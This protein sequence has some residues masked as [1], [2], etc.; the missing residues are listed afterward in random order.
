MKKWEREEE[1]HMPKTLDNVGLLCTSLRQE[2]TKCL[3]VQ[4]KIKT[5]QGTSGVSDSSTPTDLRGTDGSV[6]PFP[7]IHASL[8]LRDTVSTYPHFPFKSYGSGFMLSCLPG[9][10]RAKGQVKKI[11]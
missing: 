2:R 5:R 7:I 4:E 1:Y 3:T 10:A 8:R 11:K 9:M 6:M